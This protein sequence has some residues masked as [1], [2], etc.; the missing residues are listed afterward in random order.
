MTGNARVASVECHCAAC[1]ALLR[2]GARNRQEHV[3]CLLERHVGREYVPASRTLARLLNQ[4]TRLRPD[5][6]QAPTS[7]TGLDTEDLPALTQRKIAADIA[8]ATLLSLDLP[9]GQLVYLAM[10]LSQSLSRTRNHRGK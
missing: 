3:E 2:V 1:F 6:A 9:G 5:A 7:P 10:C 4:L 8:R